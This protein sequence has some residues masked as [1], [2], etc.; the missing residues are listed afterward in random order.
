MKRAM[1]AY[2]RGE[3]PVLALRLWLAGGAISDEDAPAPLITWDGA[4][5]VRKRLWQYPNEIGVH[6]NPPSRTLFVAQLTPGTS[7]SAGPVPPGHPPRQA[8]R[9]AHS[10]Q[11]PLEAA[12]LQTAQPAPKRFRCLS[13]RAQQ[14]LQAAEEESKRKDRAALKAR[15]TA[16]AARERA[17]QLERARTATREST[18]DAHRTLDDEVAAVPVARPSVRRVSDAA[19]VARPRARARR[20]VPRISSPH[21]D[22]GR[23]APCAAAGA[24]SPVDPS[25]AI[26]PTP[27]LAVPVVAMPA[28]EARAQAPTPTPLSMA[29]SDPLRSGAGCRAP[30]RRTYPGFDTE[31]GAQPAVQATAPARE[32][33]PTTDR[34]SQD[35]RPFG[36]GHPAV[37]LQEPAAA[38]DGAMQGAPLL[39]RAEPLQ[40]QGT[41]ERAPGVYEI[42]DMRQTTAHCLA[43][44]SDDVG[45]AID[46]AL[47]AAQWQARRWTECVSNYQKL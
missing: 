28:P 4:N 5:S 24:G 11:T 37:V 25:Q 45:K 40:S 36:P 22:Q 26:M 29:V 18:G 30:E 35:F 34:P 47:R 46:R 9:R 41:A 44:L 19:N 32:T 16:Q 8:L 38:D 10:P 17:E 6:A 39:A 23:Q 31:P 42:L 21:P 15:Q 1:W 33:L 3:M 20:P 12:H 7:P 2:S 27:S 43:V 14:A 13:Q